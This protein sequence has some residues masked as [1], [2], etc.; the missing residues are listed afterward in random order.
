M[1]FTATYRPDATTPITVTRWATRLVAAAILTI[2][3]VP[4]FTGQAGA[5]A[6][7]LPGGAPMVIGIGVIEL[8][9]VVLVLIPRTAVIGGGLATLIMAG[10][11]VSHFGPV[12]FDGDFGAMFAMAVIALLAAATAAWL[13]WDARGRRV[14]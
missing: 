2:G 9:A 4:K 13:E 5:L 7:V 14:L 3:L 8:I 11:I 10:A 12:G 6:D 1:Q